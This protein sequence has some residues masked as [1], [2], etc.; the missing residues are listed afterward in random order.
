MKIGTD[1]AAAPSFH[2]RLAVTTMA[3]AEAAAPAAAYVLIV[4]APRMPPR[5]LGGWTS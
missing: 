5:P 4:Y 1:A 3:A 2:N